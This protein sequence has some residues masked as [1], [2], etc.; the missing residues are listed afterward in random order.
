MAS[1][2]RICEEGGDG[3]GVG[4]SADA[5]GGVS[6][7]SNAAGA[8][9]A[10]TMLD[11]IFCGG[12]EHDEFL[13]RE[14]QTE[15]VRRAVDEHHLE[16]Q[17]AEALQ[18]IAARMDAALRSTDAREG[19]D[20]R[21]RVRPAI[22]FLALL[23]L[24]HSEPYRARVERASPGLESVVFS[25]VEFAM[26]I[27]PIALFPLDPH[28]VNG[29]AG[30][31]SSVAPERRTLNP[32]VVAGVAS[33]HVATRCRRSFGKFVGNSGFQLLNVSIRA[34]LTR[35]EAIRL[36]EQRRVR[37]ASF[38]APAWALNAD[39]DDDDDG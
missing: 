26:Y 38:K 11:R 18:R 13:L 23:L 34:I 25:L 4:V 8:A 19:A 37:D 7:D 14:M 30:Q 27:H 1:K 16:E 6:L 24:M 32:L 9:G 33:H 31:S 22:R 28:R 12:P 17:A 29:A 2:P 35:M 10:L 15:I 3:V 20:A 5:R 21:D 36:E 39:L